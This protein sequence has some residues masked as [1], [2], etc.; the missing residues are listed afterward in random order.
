VRQVGVGWRETPGRPDRPEPRTLTRTRSELSPAGRS[1]GGG[2]DRQLVHVVGSGG[3]VCVSPAG[4]GGGVGRP[5][6]DPP[7]PACGATRPPPADA[8]RSM[9][10]AS[11]PSPA[12]SRG[13][14]A[15]PPSLTRPL[16]TLSLSLSLSLRPHSLASRYGQGEGRASHKTHESRARPGCGG[17]EAE[18]S[19]QRGQRTRNG[20]S[21]CPAPF[22]FH[23]TR[24]WA[25]LHVLPT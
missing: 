4:G 15:L 3:W 7:W 17:A 13:P 9:C 19:Q 18:H 21:I 22:S 23:V 25:A 6:P 11:G 16:F 24:T 5:E 2:A 1:A 12:V 14:L 20:G 10:R 8:V